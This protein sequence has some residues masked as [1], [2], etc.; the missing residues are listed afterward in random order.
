VQDT[1][2][3][4]EAAMDHDPLRCICLYSFSISHLAAKLQG[5]DIKLP[6]TPFATALILL[7]SPPVEGCGGGPDYDRARDASDLIIFDAQRVS[8]EPVQ[9]SR[10][11]AAVGRGQPRGPGRK[12]RL[13]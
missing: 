8:A 1:E 3:E 10:T 7:V 4:L 2:N 11:S 12:V 6:P 13:A 9:I 5:L